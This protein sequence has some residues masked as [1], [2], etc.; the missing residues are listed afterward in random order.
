MLV[1]KLILLVASHPVGVLTSER[2]Y[3]G[4]ADCRA[5]HARQRCIR[6]LAE[7]C[8]GDK[9]GPGVVCWHTIFVVNSDNFS[10][11]IIAHDS[12]GDLG[13]ICGWKGIPVD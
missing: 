1:N 8:R 12:W 7:R 10:S 13:I 3:K 2:G 4:M 5:V 11:C 9:V 6:K